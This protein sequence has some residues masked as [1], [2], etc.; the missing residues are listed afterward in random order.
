MSSSTSSSTPG[1]N[2]RRRGGDSEDASEVLKTFRSHATLMA[3]HPDIKP[4]ASP[5]STTTTATTSSSSSSPSSATKLLHFLLKPF[6][7]LL[8]VLLHL[9]HEL[10]VSVGTMKTLFQ[11]FFLPHLFPVSPEIVRVLRMDLED[12]KAPLAKKPAHLAVVL[13]VAVENGAQGD[14]DWEAKVA[15][16]AQWAVASGIRTLSIMRNDAIHPEALESLQ[17]H[18]DHSIKQFYKEEKNVPVML[19]RT[20]TPVEELDQQERVD[21]V[22][23]DSGS[24]VRKSVQAL[25]GGRR[26]DLDVVILSPQ[27]GHDRL[28][29]HIK[30]LGE[31]ALRKEIESK[32]ITMGYME[33]K[34][35]G[36]LSEPE[37]VII[38]KDDLDL[39]SYPPWNIRLTEIY[40]HPDQAVIP[41]Y[42]MYLRALH[43]YAKCDQRFGK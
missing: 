27:D 31:A 12:D 30:A 10:M 28:A 4:M 36:E 24:E 11:V 16:L 33:K 37:L 40:H 15:Q 26:Y 43:R 19:V 2:L 21:L 32:D 29:G 9:G 22:I 41:L 7:F 5:T 42:T 25:H 18:I 23:T 39:S 35:S 6:Y 8:F 17:E 20:L 38:L 1:A 13:A 34:L 14:E 3:D